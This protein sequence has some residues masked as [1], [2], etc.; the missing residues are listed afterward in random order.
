V[1]LGGKNR[2][3]ECLTARIRGRVELL[4][5]WTEVIRELSAKWGKKLKRLGNVEVEAVEKWFGSLF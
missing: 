5:Y 2:K 4:P 1:I 3:P